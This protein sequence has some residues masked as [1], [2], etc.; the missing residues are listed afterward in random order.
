MWMNASPDDFPI[1]FEDTSD[2]TRG[3]APGSITR[4]ALQPARELKQAAGSG[5]RNFP[6]SRRLVPITIY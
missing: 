1:A 2:Q 5:L 6:S 4:I 3:E